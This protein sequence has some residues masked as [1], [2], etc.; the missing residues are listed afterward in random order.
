MATIQG[1][2]IAL[3]GRPADP[4][5]L[6]FFNDATNEGADLTA[7]GDLAS[8]AEYQDRFTGMSDEE[9]VQSIYLSLF[10][11]E[12]EDEGV[13]FFVD[14]LADGTYTIND[15]A[16]AILDGAQGTDLDT[17]NAKIAAADLFL[18]RLDQ[19]EEV[20][21]YDGA[22]AADLVRQ[23][24]DS[25][26]TDN[27][28]TEA[29]IDALILEL[30]TQAGQNPGGGGGAGDV[31]APVFS[32]GDA[33]SID[34]NEAA[35][36]VVY[37]A[38]ADDDR[39]AVQYS[40]AGA[41]AGEFTIDTA[42]G[43]VTI[44]DTKNFEADQTTYSIDVL[45][46]DFSGNVA[47]QSVTISINDVNEAPVLTVTQVENEVAENNASRVKIADLS[48]VDPDGDTI[49]FSVSN[50]NFEIYDG[51]LYLK[52]G[53]DFETDG[54]QTVTVTA[55]DG[56]LSDV[57]GTISVDVTD[58]A[59]GTIY[60]YSTVGYKGAISG[61]DRN[62]DKIDVSDIDARLSQPGNQA[63]SYGGEDNNASYGELVW[64]HTYAWVNGQIRA[65]T[66][67][68]ADNT[69]SG[70]TDFELYLVGHINLTA[71][72]FIL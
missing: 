3:F 36:S 61:F 47:T 53:I 14:G 70:G 10:E 66:Y 48:A 46:A 64:D 32:S 33:G 41:D 6:E 22:D 57:S 5:G 11:R 31:V 21:A 38:V 51:D 16:I 71:D 52:S 35:G 56:S 20:E 59:E 60:E 1:I 15:I 44:N 17:V 9:I 4:A 45:A 63:F 65:V 30:Q 24:F 39:G 8:T 26:D 13:Q 68:E 23:Y 28:P 2:Y 55:S 58:V 34:E 37:T 12:G 40:L 62:T 50:N 18:E 19:D 54:D 25:V 27:V 29:E 42:T 49:T 43:V 67:I 72:N 7:I 69:Q